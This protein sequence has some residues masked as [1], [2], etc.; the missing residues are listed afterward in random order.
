MLLKHTKTIKLEE[1]SEDDLRK[2][3]CNVELLIPA[4][5]SR[6]RTVVLIRSQT[7]IYFVFA[8]SYSLKL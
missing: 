2:V 3:N 5:R 4:R 8:Y 6:F 1:I 7:F